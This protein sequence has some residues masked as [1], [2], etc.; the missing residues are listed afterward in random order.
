[1]KKAII[2]YFSGTGNTEYAT[3]KFADNLESSGYE[4]ETKP[5]DFIHSDITQDYDLY[6]FGF[7]VYAFGA[8]IPFKNFLESFLEYHRKVTNKKAFVFST[9][10]GS[11]GKTEKIIAKKLKKAGFDVK[12]A[13]FIKAPSNYPASR[14]IKAG[15]SAENIREQVK[16][17][18]EIILYENS[19]AK[20]KRINF[21]KP[22]HW[23]FE[24]LGTNGFARGLFSDHD[25]VKCKNCVR[26]CPMNNI[27]LIENKIEFGNNCC[28]CMRC[29][30]NCPTTAINY[31]DKTKALPQY[32]G[33]AGDYKPP[34]RQA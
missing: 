11:S 16:E 21:F 9:A 12:A 15:N 28:N 26:F 29:L 14:H 32:H 30:H 5:V 18:A 4:T 27:S 19:Q 10:G 20:T 3:S 1:M 33:P 24:K 7:P 2:Y 8:P 13:F 34:M 22:I 25:C 6:G 31:K 17:A 23:L